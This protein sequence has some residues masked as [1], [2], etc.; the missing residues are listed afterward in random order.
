M[1]VLDCQQH[2]ITSSSSSSGVLPSSFSLN[3]LLSHA[4]SPILHHDITAIGSRASAVHAGEFS[5]SFGEFQSVRQQGSGVFVD[6]QRTFQSA[7]SC[8][9]INSPPTINF[10]EFFPFI[11]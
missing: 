1:S 6:S 7:A 2:V 10:G 5:A 11:S 9:V 3:D 4:G 8:A